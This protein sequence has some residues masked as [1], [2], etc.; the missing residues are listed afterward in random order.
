M[1]LDKHFEIILA[2]VLGSEFGE[3]LIVLDQ[4]DSCLHGAMIAGCWWRTNACWRSTPKQP[5]DSG[6][7]WPEQGALRHACAR[8]AQR[9]YCLTIAGSFF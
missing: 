6:H 3:A 7:P 5:A 8:F 4:Q 1:S 9:T 2:Q